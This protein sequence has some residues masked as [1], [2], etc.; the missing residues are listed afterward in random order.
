MTDLPRP[1]SRTI[2]ELMLLVKE[3]D[4]LQAP[5]SDEQRVQLA[6]AL[7]HD[8]KM[9][10]LDE[11]FSGL[12]PTAVDVMS[13]VLR[14]AANTGAPVVFSSHQLELVEKLSD[15]VGIISQGHMVAE[16]TVDELRSTEHQQFAIAVG[17]DPQSVQQALL[18]LGITLAADPLEGT[19]EAPRRE[20]VTRLV[21]TQPVGI[22]DQDILRAAV[23]AGAVHEFAPRRP[24]LSELF[25]N[26]VVTPEEEPVD[27]PKKKG[28]FSFGKKGVK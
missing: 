8:P 15:R 20:G 22:S 27:K 10:V 16:G 11:P 1:T 25:N 3:L 14:E 13:K 17:S 24:H 26:V 18:P 5:M 12:D 28:L 6:A 2:V 19:A 4:A 21:F 7:V 23:T 9:L